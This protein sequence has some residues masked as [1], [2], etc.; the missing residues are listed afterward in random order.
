M[1]S[2]CMH[3]TTT[4]RHPMILIQVLWFVLLCYLMSLQCLAFQTTTNIHTRTDRSYTSFNY[5]YNNCNGCNANVLGRRALL[6]DGNTSKLY[7]IIGT[8]SHLKSRLSAS[9]LSMMNVVDVQSGLHANNQ[10]VLTAILGISCFGIELEKRTKIGKALSAPLASMAVALVVAN[11]GM[12]PY[13][14]SIYGFV[15]MYLV[16]LAVPM[17]LFDSDLRRVVKDTGSLLR[18]FFVGAFATVV[19]T[20]GAYPLVPMKGATGSGA[21]GEGWKIASALAARHIGGAVNFVAVA[22][23]LNIDAVSVSSAIAADNIVVSLYFT[24]LFYLAKEG[25]PEV[26]SQEDDAKNNEKYISEESFGSGLQ[27]SISLSSI[28]QTFSIASLICFLGAELTKKIFPGVSSLPLISALT[29]F[30]ATLFPNVF[31]RN[32]TTGTAIGILF[33]QMFLTCSGAA[34]SIALVVKNA[35]S[36][37]LFSLLQVGFHFVILMVVGRLIFGEDRNEL[38]L[39]SNANVGG[40]TTAAAMAQAKNWPRL[41]MPA[42]LIGIL[43]Y[44]TG[45]AI[46][47][48]IA[49]ILRRYHLV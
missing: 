10:Y 16:P 36:V 46:A 14:S 43:G 40:P 23:T 19:G 15:N 44:S 9:R 32:R 48:G 21:V 28:G 27:S 22:E 4:A 45:T 3:Y 2:K 42:L 29:V 18:C 5:N 30:A 11:V 12:I 20:F 37:F 35:P 25:L 39:A 49:Q 41:V 31:E 13:T 8:H 6:R 26:V 47:L 7:P 24:L 17:L 33:M 38:L 34:G 1:R